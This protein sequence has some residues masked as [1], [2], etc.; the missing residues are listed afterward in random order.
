MPGGSGLTGDSIM[1]DAAHIHNFFDDPRDG[2]R[3]GGAGY[4]F[5]PGGGR[6]AYTAQLFDNGICADAGPHSDGD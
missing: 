2:V 3:A 1:A 5:L 6:T 4:A